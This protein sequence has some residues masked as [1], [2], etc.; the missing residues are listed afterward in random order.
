MNSAGPDSR[1]LCRQRG[2]ALHFAVDLDSDAALPPDLDG[3]AHLCREESCPRLARNP[4]GTAGDLRR[5]VET[6]DMFRCKS[7]G[8]GDFRSGGIGP[9]MRVGQE[10]RAL[11]ADQQAIEDYSDTPGSDAEMSRR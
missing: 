3:V 1:A 10:G 4:N 5:E 9:D 8:F 11:A 7:G 2:I 6:S